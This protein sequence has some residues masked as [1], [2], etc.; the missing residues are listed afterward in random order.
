M[1]LIRFGIIGL[2]RGRSYARVLRLVGGA[3]VVALYDADQSRADAAAH[4][5]GARA[6]GSLE[7]FLSSEIDAVVVA[8][9]IPFHAEQSGAALAAGKHV[10]CEVTACDTL[11]AARSLVAAARATT[12]VY[13]FA[14]NYRY[15]DEVEQLRRMR[16]DGHF[17]ELYY[18]EGEYLHD[19]RDL[20]VASDG[21]P[22]WRAQPNG[23][24][25]CTHSIGPLL[26]ILDD[27]VRTVSALASRSEEDTDGLPPKMHVLQM[28]TDRGATLR[29]RVDIGS[30]RPHNMAH[31][32][33]QGTRGAYEAWRGLGDRSKV[34]LVDEHEPSRVSDSACW[35]PLEEYAARYI[36]DRLAAP[37][38]ARTGGHGSSEYWMLRDFL[39][40]VRGEIAPPIDAYAGLDYT[41]PGILA[42]ESATRR[43]APVDVPDPRA[44]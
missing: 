16:V 4:E 6:H 42:L 23:P 32:A 39:A 36:P 43:G 40:A 33:L 19:V 20:F 17:G 35:H 37:P 29:V 2:R 41:L 10:L 22:T 11:D 3:A 25:Y 21:T 1:G 27:R 34:W 38:E 26:Y 30:P 18:G 24:V 14:E 28:T 31:Y 7:A 9:P 15:L 44:W 5:I 8:S 12:A 13:M